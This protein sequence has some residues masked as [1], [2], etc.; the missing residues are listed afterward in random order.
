MCAILRLVNT[1]GISYELVQSS[2]NSV[3]I[4]V[5]NQAVEPVRDILSAIVVL[6]SDIRWCTAPLSKHAEN[7]LVSWIE[8]DVSHFCLL[9]DPVTKTA[10]ISHLE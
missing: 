9:L 2:V 4:A 7:H 5:F 10:N 8:F 3:D 1:V 6:L